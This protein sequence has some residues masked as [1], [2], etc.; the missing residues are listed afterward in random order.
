MSAFTFLDNLNQLLPHRTTAVV[1]SNGE[2]EHYLLCFEHFR[3]RM[4][5]KIKRRLNQQRSKRQNGK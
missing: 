4:G 1:G 3:G 2:S 5:F